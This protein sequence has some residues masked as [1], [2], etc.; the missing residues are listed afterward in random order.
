MANGSDDDAEIRLRVVYEASAV[1][2]DAIADI[3]RLKEETG[4]LTK[5]QEKTLQTLEYQKT[6]L[7]GVGSE[8]DQYT[9][10]VY[11]DAQAQK[12]MR[13]MLEETDAELQ[14]QATLINS[15]VNPALET[16]GIGFEG[17]SRQAFA[18]ERVFTA[19]A[20]GGG[21][22]ARAAPMLE[23]IIK[24]MG[25][26]AGMGFAIIGIENAVERV[27]PA[28][29]KLWAKLYGIDEQAKEATESLDNLLKGY[30]KLAETP[31]ESAKKTTEAVHKA[32]ISHGGGAADIAERVEQGLMKTTT[33]ESYLSPFERE[34]LAGLKGLT[35]QTEPVKRQIAQFEET[36]RTA[37]QEQA[38]RFVKQLETDRPTRD[39]LRQMGV[40]G[41]GFMTELD[42]AEPEAQA[43]LKQT[44]AGETGA[45][46]EMQTWGAKRKAEI[47]QTKDDVK[48]DNDLNDMIESGDKAVR[49]KEARD[50]RNR[51]GYNAEVARIQEGIKRQSDAADA[52]AAAA[53]ARQ[54]A[55]TARE[56]TPQA[57]AEHREKEEAGKYLGAFQNLYPD[58]STELQKAAARHAREN[59]QAGIDMAATMK[60]A[61]DFAM[62]QARADMRR[63]VDAGLKRMYSGSEMRG[64]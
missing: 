39:T 45:G 33:L 9:A 12:L 61:A 40:M 48:Y 26:P 43:E 52:K 19:M 42:L 63:G 36:A 37:R 59:H 2:K 46:K 34:Q 41:R 44:I 11:A 50:E 32:I 29:E 54:D 47:K 55:K 8:L 23:G 31:S 28:L 38:K 15:T 4:E 64:Q 62:E 3:R 20:G 35:F 60:Q 16:A 49:A 5:E 7:D 30:E 10:K 1:V 58:A 18:A 24:T 53:K 25:G 6:L 13:Q 22:L 57:I 56:S 17:L 27:L 21:G 14:V 51:V